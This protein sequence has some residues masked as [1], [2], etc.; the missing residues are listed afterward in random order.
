MH[1]EVAVGEVNDETFFRGCSARLHLNLVRRALTRELCDF[2]RREDGY[3][4]KI[5]YYVKIRGIDWK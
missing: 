4:Q 2:G 3:L 1:R 5:M